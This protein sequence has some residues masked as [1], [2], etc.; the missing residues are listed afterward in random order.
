MHIVVT[1]GGGFIGRNLRVRLDEIGFRNITSIDR[2]N[3]SDQLIQ[4][5]AEADFVFHLAGVNRPEQPSEFD[6]GNRELTATICS[7][8]RRAG[9]VT[10]IVFTSSTQVSLGN[11]YGVSKREAEL[12]VERYSSDT[13]ARSYCLRLTNVFGKWSRPN[14]NSVVATFCYN[15]ARGLPIT[16]TDPAAP[17]RLVYVDDVIDTMIA[18]LRDAPT[19]SG[20]IDV[21]PVY[22]TTVGTVA[23]MLH[24]FASSRDGFVIPPVGRGLERALFWYIF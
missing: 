22:E 17:L 15:I 21:R 3:T 16:V 20:T 18:I 5:L 6:S 12:E 10:P 11:A 1:G 8:L 9:R 19:R 14:Y 4:A 23:E 2:E 24:N 7:A 13:G